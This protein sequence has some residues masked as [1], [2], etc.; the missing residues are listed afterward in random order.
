MP[1][2]SINAVLKPPSL[3]TLNGTASFIFVPACAAPSNGCCCSLIEAQC[4]MLPYYS[5]GMQLICISMN[6]LGEE[7]LDK[8]WQVCAR[9]KS[10][11]YTLSLQ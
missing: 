6:Q 7:Q 5:D 1:I 2:V 10:S 3:R 9:C 4:P 11:N 8:P